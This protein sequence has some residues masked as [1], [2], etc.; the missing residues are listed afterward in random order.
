M[1]NQK[2]KSSTF[3]IKVKKHSF[4]RACTKSYGSSQG[5]NLIS[6]I[7]HSKVVAFVQKIARQINANVIQK[8]NVVIKVEKG[9]T[10]TIVNVRK[11]MIQE[12]H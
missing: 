11:M 12:V 3:T 6:E 5:F 8:L 1:P 10:K 9:T 4:F 2:I 7:D